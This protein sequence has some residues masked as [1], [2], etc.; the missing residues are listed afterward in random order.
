MKSIPRAGD[1][2][3]I[4]LLSVHHHPLSMTMCWWSH[5]CRCVL[6]P[7]FLVQAP[8]VIAMH[9]FSSY[10]FTCAPDALVVLAKHLWFWLCT[11]APDYAPVILTKHLYS[12]LCTCDSEYAPAPVPCTCATDLALGLLSMHLCSWSMHLCLLLCTCAPSI[13]V[14]VLLTMHLCSCPM[15]LC[16]CPVSRLSL[17]FLTN[18][19][20]CLC[21][22]VH[23]S[24]TLV[25]NHIYFWRLWQM[26][27]SNLS[28]TMQAS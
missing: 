22:H 19:R 10:L 18:L 8:G 16:S 9:L 1:W 5:P 3:S 28:V 15:H 21:A 12:W 27:M 17:L 23:F 6:V 24:A 14:P 2:T 13:H 11:C 25:D 4:S 7:I 26:V 20:L